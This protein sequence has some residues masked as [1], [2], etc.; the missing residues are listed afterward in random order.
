MFH[1]DSVLDATRADFDR[2]LALI[3]EGR[4]TN[5]STKVREGS[6]LLATVNAAWGAALDARKAQR[7]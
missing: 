6:A 2:A 4:T 3:A 7:P 5:N 1:A